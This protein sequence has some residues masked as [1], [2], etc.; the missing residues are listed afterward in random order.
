MNVTETHRL[1]V[2]RVIAKPA[3]VLFDAWITPA[4]AAKFLGEP[5]THLTQ[6]G[7]HVGAKYHIDMVYEGKSY[8]HD[9]EYLVIDP[10]R[11]LSFT[12]LSAGTGRQRTVVTIDFLPRGDSTEVVLAHEGLPSEAS[13]RDHEGGWAEIVGWLAERITG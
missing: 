13:R 10:P 12:W 7:V 5:G 2:R 8:P 9:G 6:E 3:Q 11:R 4:T 1:E